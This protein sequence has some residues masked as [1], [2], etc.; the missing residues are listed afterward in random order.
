MNSDLDNDKLIGVTREHLNQSVQDLDQNT[1]IQLQRA[2]TSA[3]QAHQ[4][5]TRW[6]W[7]ASGF[8]L[9]CTVVG[10]LIFWPGQPIQEENFQVFEDLELLASSEP[11]DFYEDMEFYGWLEENDFSS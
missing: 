6:L 10:M 2:R 7:P 9:A 3:I 11:L 8:A 4:T 1:L 5:P